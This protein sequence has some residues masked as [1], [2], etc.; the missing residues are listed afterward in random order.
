MKR[1]LRVLGLVVLI[2]TLLGIAFMTMMVSMG[3]GRWALTIVG[4]LVAA[5]LAVRQVMGF[6]KDSLD[7]RKHMAQDDRDLLGK[8]GSVSA[9]DEA[10]DPPPI[11]CPPPAGTLPTWFVPRPDEQARLLTALGIDQ[12]TEDDAAGASHLPQTVDVTG[13]QGMGGVGKTV[14]AAWLATRCERARQAWPGGLLWTSLGP[15]R[16]DQADASPILLEWGQALGEDLSQR[17]DAES[18]AAAVCRLLAGQR[19]LL[20]VDDV[21]AL[22]PARLLL[23]CAVEGCTALF[24]TRDNGLAR[25]LGVDPLPLNVMTEGE[26][27]DLLKRRA[28]T[29]ASAQVP[30]ADRRELCQRLGY[31]PLALNLAGAALN[32]DPG[33]MAELLGLL[34]A[35]QGALNALNLDEGDTR[36]TSLQVCLVERGASGQGRR[37]PALRGS[38]RPG[39]RGPLWPPGCRHHVGGRPRRSRRAGEPTQ[40]GA[41]RPDRSTRGGRTA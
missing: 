4:A 11:Y 8:D 20:V 21:W 41:P 39:A 26:A 32:E 10:P 35:R 34:R 3:P 40:P 17:P 33:R 24:T 27:L 22:A 38:G 14:L 30:V 7:I 18:R 9:S 2:L 16:L 6:I 13:L 31:L 5:F 1:W 29:Y 15:G 37:A 36:E 28:G 12:P 19:I 23:G 25:A